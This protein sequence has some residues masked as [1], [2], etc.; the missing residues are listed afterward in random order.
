MISFEHI[1]LP[2]VPGELCE[3]FYVINETI[4]PTSKVRGM[5]NEGDNN[6]SNSIGNSNADDNN[7]DTTDISSPI[8]ARNG[9]DSK[10][11]PNGN[12]SRSNDTGGL[13]SGVQITFPAE[14]PGSMSPTESA[15]GGEVGRAIG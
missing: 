3:I 7:I 9:N 6:N 15:E 5:A 4:V 14:S 10:N 13:L 2:L 1:R 11:D 12:V 8:A